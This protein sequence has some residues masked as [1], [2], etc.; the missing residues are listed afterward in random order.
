MQ[1]IAQM[2]LVKDIASFYVNVVVN[3]VPLVYESF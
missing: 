3:L 1:M 2:L